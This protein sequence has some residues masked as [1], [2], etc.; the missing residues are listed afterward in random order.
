MTGSSRR[1]NCP[2]SQSGLGKIER[3]Y[4][5]DAPMLRTSTTDLDDFPLTATDLTVD[6]VAWAYAPRRKALDAL[7]NESQVA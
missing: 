1:I 4:A 2:R 6:G 5:L 7:A 3:L